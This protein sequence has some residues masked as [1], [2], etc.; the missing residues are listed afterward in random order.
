MATTRCSVRSEWILAGTPCG[1]EAG[2]PGDGR[3]T[4]L[5]QQDP[6]LQSALQPASILGSAPG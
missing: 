4:A 3:V 5:S 1:Q 2:G 6:L